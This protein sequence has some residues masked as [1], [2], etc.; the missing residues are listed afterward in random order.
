MNGKSVR[1][2]GICK[3]YKPKLFANCDGG[4]GHLLRHQKSCRKK[5][6]HAAMV[7]SMLALNP[8]GSIRNWNTNL[9][10]LEL[11]YVV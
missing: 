9:M 1:V 2:A 7:Q 3:F 11:S 5:F 10:L 8:D 6:D 4:T